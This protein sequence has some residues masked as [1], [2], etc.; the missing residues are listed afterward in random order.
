M[1]QNSDLRKHAI[2]SVGKHLAEINGKEAQP[3]NSVYIQCTSDSF[4]VQHHTLISFS[5][6]NNRVNLGLQSNIV[7]LYV[8]NKIRTLNTTCVSK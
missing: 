1:I 5:S 7:V 8:L 2:I 4:H 6:Q 3:F